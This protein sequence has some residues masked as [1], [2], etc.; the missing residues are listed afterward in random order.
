MNNEKTRAFPRE[1]VIS[2]G[3]GSG[4]STEWHGSSIDPYELVESPILLDACRQSKS[5]DEV[6]ELLIEA[7]YDQ[8]AVM[9]LY[10]GG[11][12]DAVV[13]TVHGPYVVAEYD[14]NES[15]EERDSIA[16]RE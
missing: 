13:T 10:G 16:W 2:V 3:Y 1:V 14:G 11:W 4:L 12:V 5:W 7:G 6:T 15:V 9:R 8:G